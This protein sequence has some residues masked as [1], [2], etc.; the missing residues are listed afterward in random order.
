MYVHVW[1]NSATKLSHE[2][3]LNMCKFR[4]LNRLRKFQGEKKG[5]GEGEDGPVLPP[6]L[7]T[8]VTS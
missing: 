5:G 3:Y 6:V 7:S 4:E 2:S 1:G 8:V